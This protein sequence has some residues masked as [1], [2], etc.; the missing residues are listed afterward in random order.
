M[1]VNAESCVPADEVPSARE[2]VVPGSV[3]LTGRELRHSRDLVER[4]A[5]LHT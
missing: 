3:L 2:G 5:E 1:K 4:G